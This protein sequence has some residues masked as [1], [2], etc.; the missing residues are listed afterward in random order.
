[1]IGRIH[2][3]QSLGAVDGP[4]VRFVVFMQGCPLR[5][6]YCHN[7]DTWDLAGGT[8]TTVEELTEQILRYQPYFGEDGGVTVTGGEPL[9][10]WEFVAELFAALKKYNIHTAL[11]TSGHGSEQAIAAVL[12]YTD[13]VL[14]DVKFPTE[15][16][17]CSLCGGSL[18]TVL[19]FLE[20]TVKHKN[21]VWIRH[22][23][24]PNLTN[25]NDNLE[26][27]L[28]LCK[29]FTNVRKVELLPF[30]KL[31]T[32]KY[33]ALGIDFPLAETPACSAETLRILQSRLPLF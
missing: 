14:C 16:Q 4:G 30:R 15:E 13:L 33:Q 27:I 3:V 32:E 28:A 19:S 8:E 24:V 29:P 5:C 25:S 9:M 12:P 6:A 1:M 2:S 20:R 11:D 7:P 17:Y 10:Q 31:C 21:D 23:V 26:Q 22:V 18:Q